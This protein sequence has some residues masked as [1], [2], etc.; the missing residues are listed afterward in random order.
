MYKQ[1]KIKMEEAILAAA[2]ENIIVYSD[3][4]TDHFIIRLQA[5]FL[6]KNISLQEQTFL[7]VVS[8]LYQVAM[9]LRD[10]PLKSPQT[11]PYDKSKEELKLR[12]LLSEWRRLQNLSESDTLDNK[13][14]T[15][16][17]A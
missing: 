5:V 6:M 15:S 12:N 8:E 10:L 13:K 14:N 17:S 11:G 3:N 9:C 16:T 4:V 7:C 2:F 1:Q